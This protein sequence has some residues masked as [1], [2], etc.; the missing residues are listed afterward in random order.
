MSKTHEKRDAVVVTNE[1]C[2]CDMNITSLRRLYYDSLFW[3]ENNAGLQWIRLMTRLWRGCTIVQQLCMALKRNTYVTRVFF[4]I[5]CMTS[6][7]FKTVTHVSTCLL[8]VSKVDK[9][10]TLQDSQERIV[11]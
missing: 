11:T 9:Y 7:H 3:A 10:I 6:I 8:L 4:R 1:Q 5:G 2:C